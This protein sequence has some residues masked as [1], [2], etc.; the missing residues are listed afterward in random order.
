[1]LAGVKGSAMTFYI[2]NKLTTRLFIGCLMLATGCVSANADNIVNSGP[3]TLQTTIQLAQKN[4]PWLVG[5]QHMQDS[6]ESM[7]IA[8]GA[9]PD[10][11]M[12]VS[13]ANIAAD[14]FDFN[15]E[16]MTQFKVG[17]SQM[18]PRGDSL[19]LKQAQLKLVGSQFPFQ[20][21]DRRAKVAVTAAKLWLDAYKAQESIALIENDR[22][23]F[24]QLA[25]VAQASYSSALGKT[26]QQD[27]VRAQLELTRLDDRL[28]MLK[29]E[30]EMSLQKLSEWLSDFQPEIPSLQN[31]SPLFNPSALTLAQT[32][33]NIKMLDKQLYLATSSIKPQNLYQRFSQHPSVKIVEQKIKA[34]QS[35]VELA[36]QSY[37]P[38]WGISAGYGVRGDAPL[39]AD[40]SDLFSIG[41]SF[42]IPLFTSNRQDKQVQSAI[43][44]TSAI[45][46]ERWQLLRQ[47]ISGFETNRA[48][49]LRLN[50]RQQLYQERLLPQMHDQAE[51]ALTAYTNDDG[52]FAEVVRSRIA[53][54]NA[55][56]DALS[57]NVERQKNIV[58]LN[59]FL[60]KS[61]DEIIL[62]DSVQTQKLERRLG[63]I[64]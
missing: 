37:K 64:Q 21:E 38:E 55:S 49:L 24:E 57:I 17:V 19:A 53:E 54:L 31:N 33:P 34:S 29:Q 51:A 56:I 9:L 12:S 63:D 41:V 8:S 46:T 44:K 40:R 35:G 47:L 25:D 62:V 45:K 59:Y 32:L 26:R 52:D 16:A 15:Q 6:V 27:I 50:Q 13:V 20:R 22:A 36:K 39:G 11:K 14:S 28:T 7:S 58:Q 61:A 18:F 30:Q 60:I 5:N 1:M 2:F 10:P 23:L 42:D 48:Q 43:S 3:L 4:D